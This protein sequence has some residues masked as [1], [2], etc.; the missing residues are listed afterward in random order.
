MKDKKDLKKVA[1]REQLFST[2]AHKEGLGAKKRASKATGADK[3]DDLWEAK[4][5][6]QFAKKRAKLASTARNKSKS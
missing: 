4:I 3:K 2:L 6:E 1:K 5:D